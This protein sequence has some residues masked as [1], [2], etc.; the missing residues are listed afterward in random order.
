[1]VKLYRRAAI[2]LPLRSCPSATAATCGS[3]LISALAVQSSGFRGIFSFL[4]LVLFLFRGELKIGPVIQTAT[5]NC[6]TSQIRIPAGI[7][8]R[9]TP[10]GHLSMPAD[11]LNARLT[12]QSSVTPAP[13]VAISFHLHTFLPE[14]ATCLGCC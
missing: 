13:G 8:I 1:M 14:A 7:L 9:N 6:A 5:N 11:S 4:L 10:A 2:H 3:K 12:F